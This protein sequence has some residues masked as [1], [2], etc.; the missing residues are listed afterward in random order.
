MPRQENRDAPQDLE[1][2]GYVPLLALFGLEA[3][4]RA[5]LSAVVA[6]V[7]YEV[8]GSAV[9]V[10]VV[11]A[12]NSI[13][14]LAGSLLL[15]IVTH[16][17]SR[18]QAMTLAM[19][20][21]IACGL[22]FSWRSPTALIAAFMLQIAM[23]LIFESATNV[24]LMERL[25]RRQIAAFESKRLLMAGI[26]YTVG[27]WLG[28]ALD[29]RVAPDLT[30]YLV[31]LISAVLLAIYLTNGPGRSDRP[32]KPAGPVAIPNP[33][34]FVPRFIAQP[35]LVLAWLLAFGRS[36]W[37]I[38]FFIYAPIYVAQSGYPADVGGALVSLGLM[39]MLAMPLWARFARRYG[40]RAMLTT[41]FVAVGLLTIAAGIVSAHPLPTMILL[42]VA[43]WC[44]TAID[45]AGNTPFMRAVHPYE[46]AA[47]TSVFLT[48]RHASAL[49][50]PGIFAVVLWFF[51]LGAVFVVAGSMAIGIA[52]LAR[53]LPRQM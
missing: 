20:A 52:W 22:A 21:G 12:F 34:R 8:L 11:Y 48:F 40:M 45:S 3:M 33:L 29:R 44:A 53:Y 27:P 32:A 23:N 47:M 1:L 28:V 37:W 2:E 14:G 31:S 39:P 24:F 18:R 17:L 6:I 43:A 36:G 7:A 38:M 13:F 41:S 42:C 19:T 10:S 50:S 30:F 15:P 35:R 46:R 26:A 25:P 51:P 16:R 49:V 5:L 9:L 4:V